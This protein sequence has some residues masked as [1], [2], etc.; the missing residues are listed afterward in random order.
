MADSILWQLAGGFGKDWVPQYQQG[1]DRGEQQA[2]KSNRRSVLEQLATGPDGNLDAK[3]GLTQLIRAG[4]L[5]GAAQ[6]AQTAKMLQPE[7][8]DEIKEYNLYR[9]QGGDKSFTDW[10]IA[11]KTASAPK[12]NNVINTGDNQYAKSLAELN[13]KSDF[14]IQKSGQNATN[15]I[16]TLTTMNR[17]LDNPNLY[18]GTGGYTMLRVKS[19]LKGAGVNVEGVPEGELFLALSNKTVLDATGGSLG[20]AISNSDRD[21]LQQTGPNLGN[22]PQGNKQIIANAIK[23]EQ[24]KV[25]I[26]QWA[27]EYKARNKGQLDA[28]FQDYLAQKAEQNPLFPQAQTNQ[29]QPQ[30][31]QRLAAPQVGEVRKGYRYKGGNPADQNS[32]EPAQ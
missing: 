24:R 20:V 31:Q 18:T 30:A 3:A 9:N 27:R 12:I 21:W 23:V 1:Y 28:G 7:T 25:Q 16:S 29:Q 19:M 11:I 15:A 17:L 5:Q 2:I 6:F 10:K 22:T 4:D 26:A 8:T 32:W 14:E 13:A